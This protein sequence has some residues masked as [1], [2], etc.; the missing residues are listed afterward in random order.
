MLPFKNISDTC[1]IAFSH[2]TI[3]KKVVKMH[4]GEDYLTL[5]IQ[6]T[7][8]ISNSKGLSEILTD[9]RTSTYQICIVQEKI[10]RLTTFNNYI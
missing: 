10:I 7:L 5:H 9:I 1:E 6:S 4:L 8:V 2:C 3:R